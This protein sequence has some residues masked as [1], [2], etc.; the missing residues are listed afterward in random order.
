MTRFSE[1]APG[2]FEL[3]PIYESSSLACDHNILMMEILAEV[4]KRHNLI[5]LS[6]EKPFAYINGSGKH[7]NWSLSA[8]GG[9]T[10]LFQSGEQATDTQFWMFI[11]AFIRAVH[12]HAELVRAAAVCPGN[13]YRLGENEAPV[14]IMS[15]YL[16]E[17]LDQVCKHIMGQSSG[18][19]ELKN[20]L[21]LGNLP[22]L[23]RDSIDRNRT[24]P[25]AFALNKFEIRTVGSSQTC[26]TIVTLLNTIMADA[27][28]QTANELEE[29]L[30]EGRGL[31]A[32]ATDV[33]QNTLKDHYNIVFNG[34]S[35]SAIWSEEA[36]LRGLP[37]NRTA[38]AALAVYNNPAKTQV[39]TRMGVLTDVERESRRNVTNTSFLRHITI[40][41]RT[42]LM[43]VETEIIPAGIRLQDELSR[44]IKHTKEAL[45]EE[46]G[47]VEE[48]EGKRKE[49]LLDPQVE[50]LKRVSSI[51]SQLIKL[52]DSHRS[53]L[54]EGE[55]VAENKYVDPHSVF[56]EFHPRYTKAL[57]EARELVDELE[58]MSN[59][60]PFPRPYPDMLLMV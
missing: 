44:S 38:P 12:T 39:F 47:E 42:M 55:T 31:E 35:N 34:N 13:D 29:R 58:T 26:A 27:L 59:N 28:D 25:I 10:S 16:G 32:A 49:G 60:W 37:R 43:L 4:A 22:P 30:K 7:I 24:G 46:E 48:G 52:A 19:S 20:A 45:G 40:E 6:H 8:D 11:I 9:K 3:C 54:Q 53:L 51:V 57:K 33:M 2:Q 50:R 23:A 18:G 36:Q 17:V 15:V 56:A 5:M 41:L 1:V 14:D 21:K